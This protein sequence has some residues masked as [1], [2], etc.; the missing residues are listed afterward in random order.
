MNRFREAGNT[1]WLSLNPLKAFCVC[2]KVRRRERVCESLP[3]FSFICNYRIKIKIT[4]TK[5]ILFFMRS[6]CPC[7]TVTQIIILVNMFLHKDKFLYVYTIWQIQWFSPE[8]LFSL[9]F[10]SCHSSDL[11][12]SWRALRGPTEGKPGQWPGLG[13][14]WHH[15]HRAR[16]MSNR[17]QSKVQ[18][19]GES[20]P[21]W[22]IESQ[23]AAGESQS[24]HHL[25][26]G[27]L[28]FTNLT[29][30]DFY[31]LKF[32]KFEHKSSTDIWRLMEF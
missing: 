6:C 16:P 4:S 1:G 23:P 13:P 28:M 17:T 2:C 14:W 10:M 12:P 27:T 20:Q 19:P 8:K 25:R 31:R 9:P 32:A 24:G 29:V 3:E 7:S 15:Y 26:M 30:L 5:V 11:E 21:H 22:W 18:T